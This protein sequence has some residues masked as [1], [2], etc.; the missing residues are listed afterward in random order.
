MRSWVDE[1]SCSALGMC[2]CGGRFLA[3]SY[4]QALR[5]L[6]QHE[7]TAHPGDYHAR[8]MLRKRLGLSTAAEPVPRSRARS[9]RGNP[10]RVPA[11]K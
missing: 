11:G 1:S 7:E 4:T 5:R 3:V 2:A 6:A 9:R 10:K 8:D